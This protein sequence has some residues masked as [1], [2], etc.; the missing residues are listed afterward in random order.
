ME[1]T[2]LIKK[3]LDHDLD[4]QE[5]EE[6]KSLEDADELI[7][8][9]ESL[10]KFKVDQ[11]VN[12]QQILN[13]IISEKKNTNSNIFSLLTKIAAIFVI[14]LG[15]YYFLFNNNVTKIETSYADKITTFL[16]DNSTVELN[17]VSSINFVKDSWNKKRELTLKGEAFFKVA[18]GS[19]FKVVTDQGNVT[20]LGTEFNVKAR[21]NTFQVVCYEGLVRVDFNGKTEKLSPGDSFKFGKL[22]EKDTENI[23]PSWINNESEFESEP[24]IEVIKEFERQYKVNFTINNINTQQLFTGKFNHKDLN[25]ALNSITLPLN[26]SYIIR[27]DEII[28]KRENPQ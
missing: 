3:W 6:F 2:E 10:K 1:K 25:L 21:N 11:N 26:L 24:F 14:A 12:Q 17:A 19:T 9:S 23:S 28:L 27:G 16:P 18:K 8:I 5:L 4:P 7:Q 15:S 13:N 20:V 22:I